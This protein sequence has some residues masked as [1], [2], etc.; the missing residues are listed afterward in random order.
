MRKNPQIEA[1]EQ[2]H[3]KSIAHIIADAYTAHGTIERAAQSLGM[4]P[5][6]FYGWLRRLGIRTK[7]IAVV[8]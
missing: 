8:A 2:Q 4:N 5:V 7:K 6:T 1:L 3:G